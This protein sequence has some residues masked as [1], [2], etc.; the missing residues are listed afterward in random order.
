MRKDFEE[1][2]TRMDTVGSGM[3]TRINTI[4]A[5][6]M[7][8]QYTKIVNA[9]GVWIAWRIEENIAQGEMTELNEVLDELTIQ[10]P[11]IEQMEEWMGVMALLP[12]H[13]TVNITMGIAHSSA[14]EKWKEEYHK[15]RQQEFA[16]PARNYRG[17]IN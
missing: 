17:L 11:E 3:S 16:H 12:G 1:V 13:S 7:T 8:E 14:K 5:T 9:K 2:R 6:T 15:L 4:E 10:L